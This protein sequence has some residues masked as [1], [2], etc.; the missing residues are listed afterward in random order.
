MVR[1]VVHNIAKGECEIQ[2]G[3]HKND[4]LRTA[5]RTAYE[6]K[7]LPAKRFGSLR[8]SMHAYPHA[9]I[10]PFDGLHLIDAFFGTVQLR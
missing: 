3:G 1:S 8:V 6:A 4:H 9:K 7:F 10:F 2:I 5:A